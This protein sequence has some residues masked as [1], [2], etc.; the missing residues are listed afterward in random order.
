[1]TAVGPSTAA[2]AWW[3]TRLRRYASKA[4]RRFRAATGDLDQPSGPLLGEDMER[5]EG[6]AAVRFGWR[7]ILDVA[8]R[9]IGVSGG[10]PM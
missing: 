5:S 1:M 3:P 10:V 6:L 8:A 2:I 4:G 9:R 7:V